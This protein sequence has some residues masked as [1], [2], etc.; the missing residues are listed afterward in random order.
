MRMRY[1]IIEDERFAYE[2]IKRMMERLR[3]DYKLVGWAQ[4]AEQGAMMLR[5]TETDLLISDIRLED[6]LSLDLFDQVGT[7]LPIIFTTAYDEY[8]LRA[9]DFYSIDYLLKPIE[10]EKLNKALAKME[11]HTGLTTGSTMFERFRNSYMG[12]QTK[13]RFL[14]RRGAK[15]R[16]VKVENV[17]ALYAD[18]K[19]TMLLTNDGTEY[20]IN[21]SLDDLEKRLD[22]MQ[23]F[24]VT[25]GIILNI[26][27][28]EEVVH[29]K[30]GW[31]EAVLKKPLHKELRNGNRTGD[32][33]TVAR[34]RVRDFL[35]WFD[36]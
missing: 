25:R 24:C 2:D 15:C 22:P 1:I 23:F 36:K 10:E 19:Y 4:S 33:V 30:R 7:D 20:D 12:G 6:G 11:L 16:Y 18:N 32:R 27:N 14:V 13:R 17:A 3:P 28:I 9:F 8:A 21:Y 31:V 5:E 34:D 35:K 26:D 29:D